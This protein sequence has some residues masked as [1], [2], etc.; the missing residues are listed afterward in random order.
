M[1]AH[2]LYNVCFFVSF[3]NGTGSISLYYYALLPIP[4]G[5]DTNAKIGDI[6]MVHNTHAIR[7]VFRLATVS[8]VFVIIKSKC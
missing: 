5:T 8:I 3:Y 4:V 7:S 2:F 1:H 6:M